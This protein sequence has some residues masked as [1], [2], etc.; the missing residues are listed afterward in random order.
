MRH[1]LAARYLAD[2][3]RHGG[4]WNLASV[5]WV[6]SDGRLRSLTGLDMPGE[7]LSHDDPKEK[8]LLDYSLNASRKKRVICGHNG[9]SGN[10]RPSIAML[11]LA[12]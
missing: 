6:A 8:S 7:R 5:G 11:E 9:L 1:A 3:S 2:L 4:G 12:P 10:V